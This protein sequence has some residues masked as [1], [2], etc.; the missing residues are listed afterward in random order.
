[1][2]VDRKLLV[3]AAL[4]RTDKTNARTATGRGAPQVLGGEPRAQGFEIGLAGNITEDWSV[5]GGYTFLDSEI[6]ESVN[7]AEVGNEFANI[8]PHN[9]S[10]W[11]AYDVT[12]AL[13][14]GFGATYSDRRYA[15]NTNDRKLPSYW[16]F[17]AMAAYEITENV[18]VQLNVMNLTDELYYDS[19]HAGQ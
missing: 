9:F 15:N 6:L 4:V 12:D 16:R 10:L 14:L 13:R 3:N 19:T 11:T 1:E 17:D 2:L 8:A 7:P 5:F 18:A